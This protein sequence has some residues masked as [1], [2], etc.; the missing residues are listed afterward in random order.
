MV[1]RDGEVNSQWP[2]RGHCSVR[3]HG[4]LFNEITEVTVDFNSHQEPFTSEELQ[5]GGATMAPPPPPPTLPNKTDADALPASACAMSPVSAARAAVSAAVARL[6]TWTVDRAIAALQSGGSQTS[7]SYGSGAAARSGKD[8]VET[9][10]RLAQAAAAVSA[11]RASQKLSSSSAVPFSLWLTW[12]DGL[13]PNSSTESGPRQPKPLDPG[14]VQTRAAQRH[15]AEAHASGLATGAPARGVPQGAAI[16]VSTLASAPS[17]GS[18]KGG[19]EMAGGPDQP[20]P[21][22]PQRGTWGPPPPPQ[23][24]ADLRQRL[25]EQLS[26]NPGRQLVRALLSEAFESEWQGF[27]ERCVCLLC[28]LCHGICA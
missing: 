7:S 9:K 25:V 22:G 4:S 2:H 13:L 17:L 24:Q 21:Q 27:K 6:P 20:V 14:K 19:G 18:S 16:P 5:W 15:R 26:G 12:S 11:A 28:V 10:Q 1:H 23:H 8:P 3:S